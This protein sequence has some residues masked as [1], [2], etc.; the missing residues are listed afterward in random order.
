[1]ADLV[2]T[3]PSAP[4]VAPLPSDSTA[5]REQSPTGGAPAPTS[6][7]GGTSGIHATRQRLAL[8]G[9]PKLGWSALGGGAREIFG[10]GTY[11]ENFGPWWKDTYQFGTN[12]KGDPYGQLGC[13]ATAFLNAAVLGTRQNNPIAEVA[14]PRDANL[15]TP[16]WRQTMNRNDWQPLLQPQRG[17]GASADSPANK[18]NPAVRPV[19]IDSKEGRNL[20]AQILREAKQGRPVVL[21]LDGN[22]SGFVRHTVLVT[23]YIEGKQGWDALV[24][25]DNWR[26]PT[27]EL[28]GA[29]DIR[30][31]YLTTASETFRAYGGGRYAKIDMAVVAKPKP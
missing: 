14:T 10:V 17:A 8:T 22:T 29:A 21:G 1:M 9:G 28:G 27:G 31:A 30:P 16:L 4:S 24:V 3:N 26:G 13:T 19:A 15:R 25:R 6:G 20:A 7:S 18:Y 23:G 12:S 5:P 11:T 2:A